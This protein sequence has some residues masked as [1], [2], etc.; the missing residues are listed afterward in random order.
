MPAVAE[1]A[2]FDGKSFV[3]TLTSAP[4]V[5]RMFGASDELLYVGKAGNLKKRVGS[6]FLKPQHGSAHRRDDR[7]RSR[8]SRSRS[9]AP[10]PRRCCSKRS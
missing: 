7:R 10:K 1:T 3:R 2:A 5:Y 4:G 6:Y 9:P 8:A